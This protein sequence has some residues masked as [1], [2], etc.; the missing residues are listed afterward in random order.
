MLPRHRPSAGRRRCIGVGLDA[1]DVVAPEQLLDL[2]GVGQRSRAAG[3]ACAA[4]IVHRFTRT[5]RSS[6]RTVGAGRRGPVLD[7]R[8]RERALANGLRLYGGA[9]RD[10]TS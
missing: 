4:A 3:D 1:A 7:D 10:R 8:L 5:G 2:T 9:P 6:A